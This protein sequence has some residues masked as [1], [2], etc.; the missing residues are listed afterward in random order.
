MFRTAAARPS[1]LRWISWQH[2]RH[3]RGGSWARKGPAPSLCMKPP[4]NFWSLSS[5]VHLGPAPFF[6]DS[7]ECA[8]EPARSMAA[9]QAARARSARTPAAPLSPPS[10]RARTALAHARADSTIM[11]I[12]TEYSRSRSA[13]RAHP[14][15]S[16]ASR[17]RALARSRDRPPDPCAERAETIVGRPRPLYKTS[18][19][20][21]TTL[22]IVVGAPCRARFRPCRLRFW[23]PPP[24]TPV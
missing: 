20:A 18:R 9:P 11:I 19:S 4:E 16:R 6:S 1:V 12:A 7:S 14:A 10:A 5:E 17:G 22:R 3:T 2:K 15:D 8:G 24:L 23:R 13:R 21:R